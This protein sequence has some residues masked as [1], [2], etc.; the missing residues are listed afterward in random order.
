MKRP[1]PEP[2]ALAADGRV[3]RPDLVTFNV[4]GKI[5]TVLF[6]PTLSLHPNSLLTQLAEEKQ[7][8]KDIFVEGLSWMQGCVCVCKFEDDILQIL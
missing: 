3:D 2:E 8:E 1:R 6:E 5:Y 4:S 7:M